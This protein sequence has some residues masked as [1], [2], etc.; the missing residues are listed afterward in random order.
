MVMAGEPL[1]QPDP[2]DPH[3]LSLAAEAGVHV[4]LNPGS[5]PHIFNVTII[6]PD[7]V[8][9][10]SKASGVLALNSLRV[11][12]ASVNIYE[13]LA[14]NTFVVSPHFGSPPAAELLRQQF[15]LA[16]DG[17]LD[18]IGSLEQRDEETPASSRRAG[19]IPDAVPGHQTVAPPRV[20]WFDGSSGGELVVQIRSDDRPGLLARLAAVIERTGFNISW[21]KVTTLGATVVDAFGLV[22][23]EGATGTPESLTEFERDLYAI[24]PAPPKPTSA[25]S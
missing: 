22:V 15:L 3:H 10:L 13:G 21:A 19:D 25:T 1:P 4:E 14:I 18:V 8:G 9:L 23:P 24:L 20:L 6:A 5:S 11:Y 17:D 7:R 12:S 2:I 16:L